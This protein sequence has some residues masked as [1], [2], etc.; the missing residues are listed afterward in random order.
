MPV[1]LWALSD[2]DSSFEI[3]EFPRKIAQRPDEHVVSMGLKRRE[4]WLRR[5]RAH[6]G[7]A[8]AA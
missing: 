7:R 2:K 1:A 3:R 5:Q 4:A 6:R 8:I